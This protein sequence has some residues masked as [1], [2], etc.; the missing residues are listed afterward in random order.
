MKIIVVSDTHG[1]YR[2]LEIMIEREKPFDLMIHLGDIEDGEDYIRALVDC[3]VKIVG[4]NNDF[5]TGLPVEME[6]EV[7]G[8][9]VYIAHGHIHYVY[10]G[11][12]IFKEEAR[13]RGVDVAMYGHLHEPTMEE[14]EGITILSPGSIAL[15]RQLGRHPSYIVMNV[16]QG[17]KAEY[18]TIYM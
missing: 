18:N 11:L 8:T 7:E 6:F 10:R 5:F 15:P 17:K 14:W 3:D 16:E 13:R 9:K 2:N 12:G 4:G 1:M